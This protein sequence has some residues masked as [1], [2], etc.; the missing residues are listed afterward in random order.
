MAP[1]KEL[2]GQAESAE[3][4]GHHGSGHHHGHEHEGWWHQ[5]RYLRHAPQLW[6]SP[7]NEAVVGLIDPGEGETM[8]DVGAGM[9]PAVLAAARRV[10]EGRVF[11]LDPS[12]LMRGIMRFRRRKAGLA[13]RLSIKKGKAEE[14]PLEDASVN[15]AWSINCVHHWGDDEVACTE[16]GRVMKP[17]G[18]L[19]LLDEQ[20]S[21]PAHPRHDSYDDSRHG[22][23]GFFHEIDTDRLGGLLEKAGFR[24]ERA[25]DELLDGVPVRLIHAVRLPGRPGSSSPVG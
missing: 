20:F 18:R 10:G 1:E 11:A 16:L 4:P 15:G 2:E 17:D 7:V 12:P 13:D 19:L 3:N 14:I 9:G 21:D 22:E 24:I 25:G 23:P 8:L 5:V 6:T